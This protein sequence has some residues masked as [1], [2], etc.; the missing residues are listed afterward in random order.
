MAIEKYE[1]STNHENN[2]INDKTRMGFCHVLT[3]L[4]KKSCMIYAKIDLKF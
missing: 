4:V 1:F 2:K 3:F